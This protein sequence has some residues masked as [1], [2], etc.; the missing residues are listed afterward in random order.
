V[1][2]RIARYFKP[3]KGGV[4]I[5]LVC[6]ALEGGIAG[7]TAWLVKPVLD[8]I[9]IN[10]DAKMLALL[11]VAV[12][13][14]YLI[15]GAARYVQTVVMMRVGESVILDVRNELMEAI[16]R[17]EA[18]YFDRES[19]GTL[20]SRVLTDVVRM[21]N[22]IPNLIQAVRYLLTAGGLIFVLF[23]RDWF[24][25]LI[26]IVVLPLIVWP[27][28]RISLL[29]KRHSKK[30]QEQMGD[31]AKV[32]VETFS[33]IE[34]VKAFNA[35]KRQVA[36]FREEGQRMLRTLLKVARLTGA[37]APILE[38]MGA[39]GGAFIIWYGGKEVLAG[40]TTPGTFISFL[41]AL[42]L[43]Y[44]PIK[45]A[46]SLNNILMEAM[47][48]AERVFEVMDAP[49]AECEIQG[50][51]KLDLPI[52][53]ARFEEVHFAYSADRESVLKG[54]TFRA[55]GGEMVALVG[56][57][58][59]GKSTVLK[60]LMRLYPIQSGAVVINGKDIREYTRESLRGAMAVVSQ[61]TFLFDDTVYNNIAMG[62]P[63]ASREEVLAAAEAANV[64]R[65]IETLPD[66]FETQVGERGDLL[67]GGQKQRVAIARA[68]L[69]DAPILILDE[70]TSSLD[71]ES[72]RDIQAALAVLMKGRTTFAIAHRL[73]TIRHADRILFLR[74]GR[75]VEE[76][77]HDEL[78]ARNGD[79]T[80]LCRIQFGEA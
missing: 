60:L 35:E 63:S 36:R 23:A 10:N 40:N 13:F 8:D 57:S 28:R 46:A 68:I 56:E 62:R 71:S 48:S 43:V 15:K 37:T 34:V 80:R 30:S 47:A 26:A 73:S 61:D 1:I 9:F 52:R 51:V 25:T 74:D 16:T 29:M 3:H 14:L 20:V 50:T 69:R 11:P 55:E 6:T 78:L 19:T 72:E 5:A 70:A 2:K 77:R 17:R 21:R 59:A 18:A 44:D 45:K 49:V 65:F 33:G 22:T 24:L 66:G 53:E 31:L 27:I 42:F 38:L 67:S 4:F 32:L 58:G 12:I 7:A 39:L 75:V 64:R 41:T 79:Y 76:G 54:L